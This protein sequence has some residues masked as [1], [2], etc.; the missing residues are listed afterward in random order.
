MDSGIVEV[1][2]ESARQELR[3]LDD[4]EQDV[5]FKVEQA[6]QIIECVRRTIKENLNTAKKING[7]LRGKDV[8][9]YIKSLEEV[10]SELKARIDI[11]RQYLNA[12]IAGDERSANQ[13]VS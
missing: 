4:V 8:D 13:S 12:K 6:E 9:E 1:V 3:A 5:M 10:K 11:D 2:K 7:C